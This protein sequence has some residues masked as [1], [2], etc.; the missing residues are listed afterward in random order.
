MQ[1]S[2]RNGFRKSEIICA[3]GAKRIIWKVVE[4]MCMIAKIVVKRLMIEKL[5]VTRWIIEEVMVTRWTEPDRAGQS[6]IR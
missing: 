6:R 3:A 4:T 2:L 1:E 5:V